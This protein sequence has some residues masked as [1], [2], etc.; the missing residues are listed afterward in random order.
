MLRLVAYAPDGVRRFPVNRSEL[1]VGSLPECDIFLPYTGVAQRH[2]RLLYDGNQLRIEDLG[3]RRGLLVSGRKV[4]EASLEV[5]DEIR[6]GGVT[7][8]VEDVV[9][10][11]E[12]PPPPPSEEK[13]GPPRIAPDRL[14]QHLNRIAEWV[15]AD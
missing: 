4:K 6:L 13:A 2:A 14:I 11:P 9:P 5:L 10:G 12:K 3:S 7:L 15:L 1:I 8:L